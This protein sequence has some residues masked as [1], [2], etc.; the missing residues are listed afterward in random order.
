[1]KLKGFAGILFVLAIFVVATMLLNSNNTTL[2]DTSLKEITVEP[3]IIINNYEL[4]LVQMTR[5]CNW[6]KSDAEILNCIDTNATNLLSTLNASLSSTT[7][8]RGLIL[9]PSPKKFLADIN[10]TI[11]AGDKKSYVTINASK[12]ITLS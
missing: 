6:K 8:T 11:S 5:D 1:M 10:C 2:N 7:C 3:K 9:N 4:N 12:L